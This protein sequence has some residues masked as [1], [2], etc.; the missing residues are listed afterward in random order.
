MGAP[1]KLTARHRRAAQLFA[2]GMSLNAVAAAMN[3]RQ[4]SVLRWRHGP[5]FAQL[6]DDYSDRVYGRVTGAFVK[7]L[8]EQLASP[9]PPRSSTSSPTSSL[10]RSP[11]A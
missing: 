2:L 11:E 6:V 5:G 9:Q 10:R 8:M 1:K 3:T 7:H 4:R